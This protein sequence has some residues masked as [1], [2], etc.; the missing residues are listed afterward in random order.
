MSNPDWH[1]HISGSTPRAETRLILTALAPAYIRCGRALALYCSAPD[2]ALTQGEI[3]GINNVIDVVAGAATQSWI[4]TICLTV[5]YGPAMTP[6]ASGFAWAQLAGFSGSES[7]WTNDTASARTNWLAAHYQGTNLT[8]TTGVHSRPP[9]GAGN[10]DGSNVNG[11]F[12]LWDAMV[13]KFNQYIA[14]A[15][16]RWTVYWGLP[17]SK[18]EFE[19]WNEIQPGGAGGK[20]VT[21]TEPGIDAWG[22]N[23]LNYVAPRLALTFNGVKVP[24]GTPTFLG[25]YDMLYQYGSTTAT[26]E[27]LRVQAIINWWRD[28]ANITS[29]ASFD[30]LLIN[31]Y[32]TVAKNDGSD[33]YLLADEGIYQRKRTQRF[34]AT[35]AAIRA[36]GSWMSN[37]PV[38]VGEFGAT[39]T[40]L[41]MT[42]NGRTIVSERRGRL[43]LREYDV[44]KSLGAY[45]AHLY[46]LRDGAASDPNH[47][48]CVDSATG[49]CHAALLPMLTRSLG[50]RPSLDPNGRS[51]QTA[52]A[53]EVLA[54]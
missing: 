21:L 15:I 2:G 53:W 7:D 38:G 50:A 19:L 43:L 31:D 32:V 8:L 23:M 49:A 35:M 4:P 13:V 37:L 30:R 22:K 45:R 27:I 28:A 14:Q 40:W 52:G 9:A 29:W 34:G 24:L 41:G 26:N 11:S 12:A 46:T 48:G 10:D 44:F 33:G 54:E 5:C 25:S 42:R 20:G 47:H 3:D 39:P 1:V 18:M 51:F 17:I 6:N 36:P 16:Q